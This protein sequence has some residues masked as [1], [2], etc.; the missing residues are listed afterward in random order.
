M[1][2]RRAHV[3]NATLAWSEVVRAAA[4]PVDVAAAER[5]IVA[6]APGCHAVM[7]ASGRGAIAAAVQA[8]APRGTVG[9]PAYTCIAVPNAVRT[10]GATCVF[11]DVDACGLVPAAAW[12]DCDAVIV[13]DTYGFEAPTP[14]GQLVI[15]DATHR[16]T[17]Q[18][19][20]GDA[21]V[22]NSFEHSKSLT[23]GQGGLAVTRDA[24]LAAR[25]REARDHHAAPARPLTHA[26]VTLLTLVA[27]RLQYDGRH[28]LADLLH[29]PVRRVAPFRL[30]GQCTSELAGGGVDHALLG[31]P[32]RIVARLMLS[33]VARSAA[34]AAHRARIVGIYDGAAGVDRPAHPLLRYPL[35]VPDPSVFERGLREAGWDISGRWFRAPLHPVSPAPA[36]FAFDAAQTPTAV[37]L[38]DTVVNLPTHP[39]VDERDAR[40]LV[41]MAIAAGA[42]AVA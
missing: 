29:R 34:V 30:R 22:V 33:Q 5:R 9:V 4:L 2:V 1:S 20:G 13:Q 10:G 37:R 21:V 3:P 31:P 39:L 6:S 12:P 19:R 38:A 7:F 24:A 26:L 23:A 42:E 16:F 41:H 36:T 27:G 8:L 32:N 11:A 25:M 28:R 40:E 17:L 18:P 35:R 14:R 15:R